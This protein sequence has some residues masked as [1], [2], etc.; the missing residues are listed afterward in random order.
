MSTIKTHEYIQITWKALPN[1]QEIIISVLTDI[2]E[3]FEQKE[4]ILH[5]YIPATDFEEMKLK[6][7]LNQY[8]I[9]ESIPYEV[10]YIPTQNWNQ[11]WEK[12]FD[13][14]HLHPYLLIRATHHSGESDMKY[15]HV[16]Q[17]QPK[18]A[19]GTGHHETTQMML[20]AMKSLNFNNKT[21]LDV[22]CGSG[23]LSIYAS[24]LGAK[25]VTALDIDTWSIEN[26]QEN[27]LLNHISNIEIYLGS[28]ETLD[29][30]FFDIILANINRNV[31]IAQLKEYLSRLN[32]KGFL[33]ISGFFD[34]D[35]DIIDPQ[36]A[37]QSLTFIK[38]IVQ[39]EWACCVYQK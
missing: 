10:T 31:I 36:T 34:C 28:I 35:T 16:I 13:P 9:L 4:H 2:V 24:L 15:D 32:A 21:V 37:R 38:K 14:V 1:L 23:I 8:K 3:S 5:A 20:K 26:A 11:L 25:K 33:L 30:Q 17:I 12:Q 6:N 29:N 22:G 39:N 19:F 27:A 7:I 18:M